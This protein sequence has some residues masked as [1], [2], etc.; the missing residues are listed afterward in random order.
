MLVDGAPS[1]AI[2]LCDLA[3]NPPAYAERTVSVRAL[4]S[5]TLGGGARLFDPAR[6]DDETCAVSVEV[7]PIEPKTAPVRPDRSEAQITAEVALN[8][9]VDFGRVIVTYTLREVGVV[10]WAP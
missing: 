2:S 4:V 8:R 10:R 9:R 1:A 7:F 5:R 3:R 6:P